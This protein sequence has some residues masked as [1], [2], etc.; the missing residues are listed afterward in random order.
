MPPMSPPFWAQ[1][2]ENSVAVVHPE[3]GPSHRNGFTTTG[4]NTSVAASHW[5]R[6]AEDQSAQHGSGRSGTVIPGPT[7]GMGS[8]LHGSH[9]VRTALIH[10]DVELDPAWS[11]ELTGWPLSADQPLAASADQ[12]TARV[13]SGDVVSTVTGSVGFRTAGVRRAEEAGATGNHTAIPLLQATVEPGQVYVAIV[14]L[15]GE[16]SEP[17]PRVRMN[18]TTVWVDWSDGSTGVL[19]LAG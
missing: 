19:A 9:E 6:I 3:L 8:L 11:L 15:S 12:A 14:T 2:L 17:V 5:V 7:L 1:A 13:A 4:P 16:V 10:P 18:G